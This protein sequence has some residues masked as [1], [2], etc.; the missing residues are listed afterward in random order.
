MVFELFKG[1]SGSGLEGVEARMIDMLSTSAEVLRLAVSAFE[2]GTPASE[3]GDQIRKTDRQV[4]KAERSI[5]RELV[6][7]ASVHSG[8]DLPLVLVYMSIIKDIERVGDY[9]KNIWDVAAAIE[10]G[11]DKPDLSELTPMFRRT[12]DLASEIGEVYTARDVDRATA[13][14]NQ[15]D[16]WLD[17][18]DTAV[19]E[20]MMSYVPSTVGVPKALLYRHLKRVTAHLMNVLTAVVMPFDRLDYWDEDKIDRE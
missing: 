9:A 20:L 8:A 19:E 18:Y 7:H 13:V 11:A 14:L 6:V 3:I 2:Q 5:R 10:R 4:N 12:L 1:Q 16:E 15:A 17:E